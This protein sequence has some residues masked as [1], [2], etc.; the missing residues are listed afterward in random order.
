MDRFLQIGKF[1]ALFLKE[2]I[3]S[4]L[5]TLSGRSFQT[6]G[7]LKAPRY[8]EADY[9]LQKYSIHYFNICLFLNASYI[10]QMSGYIGRKVKKNQPVSPSFL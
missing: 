7:A 1:R 2:A 8:T 5:C 9:A 10:F 6:S 3:E 4:A